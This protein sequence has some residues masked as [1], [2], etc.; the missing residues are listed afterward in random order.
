MD[1]KKPEVVV[2][3]GASGGVGRAVAREFAKRG[4]HVGL[5]ARGAEGLEG[6]KREVEQLG[7]KA[8]AIPTDV[9]RYD[10]VAEAA[11]EVERQFGAIDIW[12]NDAMVSIYGPFLKV[13]P[14]EYQHI[15]DV[16]YHGQV[17][18]TR[19]ALERMV[20]RNRGHIVQVG[21]AL[22]KRSIPLQSAYC[23]AKHAID[24][25]TESV[26]T[27]LIHMK[28]KVVL[29]V[30]Q[31]PA[32]NTTQFEWTR[33]KMSKKPRPVGKIHQPEIAARAIHWAAHTNRK[34]MW[35]GW[36]TV[37]SIVGERV[38][39]ALLDRYLAKKAWKGSMRK[40]PADPRA[41]DN[42]WKPV[43]R[44]MGS[45]GPFDDKASK[46]SSQVWL[47][48]HRAIVALAGLGVAAAGALAIGK[49]FG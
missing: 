11:A 28:S 12:I 2:V 1:Q 7:G 6:A 32:V 14:K 33:N 44:D 41:P 25:F 39:S 43:G 23:G 27:E 15:T 48:E 5:L 29:T 37:E 4:A 30:V 22:A 46:V 19:V 34:E 49:A 10:D 21:S 20:P 38:M 8:L 31:L 40:E 18:G 42:F 16:T 3:T 24:G 47:D 26:R 45:H 13:T 9:S 17:W 36:P 35:V